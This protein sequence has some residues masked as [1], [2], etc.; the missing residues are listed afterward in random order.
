M[1]RNTKLFSACSLFLAAVLS[2][3]ILTGCDSSTKNDDGK[4]DKEDK[5][6][7]TVAPDYTGMKVADSKDGVYTFRVPEAWTITTTSPVMAMAEDGSTNVNLVIEE[8]TDNQYAT[9][10]AYAEDAKVA[11]ETVYGSMATMGSPS[12]TTLDGEDAAKLTITLSTGDVAAQL[13]QIY[14]IKD[15]KIYILTFTVMSDAYATQRPQ[16]DRI[17]ECFTFD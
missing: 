16:F 15:G 8:N 13:E 11:L 1:K 12:A 3:G 17:L 9:A 10:S 6:E 7:T 2:L 14:C 5:E 4:K